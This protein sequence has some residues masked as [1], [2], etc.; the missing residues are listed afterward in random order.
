MIKPYKYIGEILNSVLF[1]HSDSFCQIFLMIIEQGR[2]RRGCRHLGKCA[3]QGKAQV[4]LHAE[5]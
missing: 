2:D 3:E 5:S 4:L 1:A